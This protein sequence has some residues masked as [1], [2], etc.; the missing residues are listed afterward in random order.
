MENTESKRVNFIWKT[1]HEDM[2]LREVLVLEPYLYRQGSKEKEAAWS[3]IAENLT[4]MG[5]KASQRSVRIEFKRK[6]AMEERA[7]G[8]DVEYTER[9]RA[10]W[11]ILERINESKVTTESKKEKEM[12][13]K[14]TAEE[15][16]KKATER[17]GETRRRHAEENEELVTPGRK[18]RRNS[19]CNGSAEGVNRSETE[20][21]GTNKAIERKRTEPNGGSVSTAGGIPESNDAATARISATTTGCDNGHAEH[22]G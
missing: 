3:K 21:A 15:M 17:F 4:S 11:D 14:A 6:E 5:I 9:D 18:R 19:E 10:M 22:F 13:E 8:V 7:S 12:E 16:R 2:P 20:R 1:M